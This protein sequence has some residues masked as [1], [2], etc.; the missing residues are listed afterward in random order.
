MTKD[1]QNSEFELVTLKSGVIS[2]RA[3]A[4]REIFHPGTGPRLEAKIL[5]VEQQRLVERCSTPGKFVIWDVGLG[6]AANVLTAIEALQNA[7]ADIEIHSFDK[8]TAPLDFALNHAR[9]L[10]YL[11]PHRQKIIQLLSDCAVNAGPRIRWQ[12]H[13]GEFDEVV[14]R[15][16]DLPA[17]HA[18]FYDP[19]SPTYNPEMW[20]LEHFKNLRHRLRPETPCM[21]TNYTRSTAVRVTLLLAGF[22]VGRGC[23]VGTKD[24][25][26][27]ATNQ[28]ELLN[29][30]LDQEWLETTVRQSSN[31]A[32]ITGANQPKSP[33]SPSDLEQ[34]RSCLAKPASTPL[35]RCAL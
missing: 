10:G 18:I 20:M 14:R 9:E 15:E 2:L 30:P 23:S 8:T 3:K 25:T 19:Y 28:R 17:P 16:R 29:H 11:E 34:L 5:H 13:L 1:T 35:D 7:V 21:M 31:A 12:L 33:I 6:A 24:E 4:N 26:T 32:P 22:F 27:V